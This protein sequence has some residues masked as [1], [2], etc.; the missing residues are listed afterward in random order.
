MYGTA[1]YPKTGSTHSLFGGLYTECTTTPGSS[2]VI[3][4]NSPCT[5]T[6]MLFTFRSCLNRKAL[7][8]LLYGRS[9]MRVIPAIFGLARCVALCVSL[10]HK[11]WRC[12][13]LH[14]SDRMDVLEAER[15]DG[16]MFDVL[17]EL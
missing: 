15:F 17:E 11:Q 12:S 10:R 9:A 13:R 5:D 1:S 2:A 14:I 16:I 7:P 6:V 4:Y 8:Y 3:S